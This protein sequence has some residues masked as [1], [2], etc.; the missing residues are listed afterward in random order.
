[1]NFYLQGIKIKMKILNLNE[2]VLLIPLIKVVF[3]FFEKRRNELFHTCETKGN[4]KIL[5]KY[6]LFYIY[7]TLM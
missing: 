7:S 1:M 3:A 2:E 4:P 5:H 6:F